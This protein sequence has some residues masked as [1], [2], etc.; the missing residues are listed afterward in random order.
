MRRLLDA[1]GHDAQYASPLPV[2]DPPPCIFIVQTSRLPTN[3]IALVYSESLF[4][5]LPLLHFVKDLLSLKSLKKLLGYCQV[6]FV[7]M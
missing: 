4:P 2:L 3:L 5:V 6:V 1:A 7:V